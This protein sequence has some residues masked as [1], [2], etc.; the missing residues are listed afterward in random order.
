MSCQCPVTEYTKVLVINSGFGK[1]CFTLKNDVMYTENKVVLHT[2]M[3]LVL[4]DENIAILP[5]SGVDSPSH[6]PYE[7]LIRHKRSF[8]NNDLSTLLP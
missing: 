4:I 2:E 7:Q 1:N 5:L 8:S 6:P 3:C